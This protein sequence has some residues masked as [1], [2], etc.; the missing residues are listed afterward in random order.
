MRYRPL[1]GRP[2]FTLIELLVV[3]AIIA[4]LIGLLLP[5][6]QK[7]R[8]AANRARCNSN[9]KQLALGCHSY[10]DVFASLPRNGSQLDLKT[11]HG[12]GADRGT[13]CCGVA[14]P[15]WSWIARMLPFTEQQNLYIEAGAP[16]NK[17]SAGRD[18][19]LAIATDL[20]ILYCPND[21]SP[22]VRNNTANLE[23]FSVAVGN[24]HGVSGSNWGTDSYPSEG[25]FNSPYRH[26]GANGSYN[27][28]EKGDGL[29][30]RADI[31]YGQR[32]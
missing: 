29:F 4:V 15:H 13:G 25:S 17:M 20:K 23:G 30:W 31:R 10:H 22:R 12:G 14:A 28:L 6:V 1:H 8:E 21:R 7:V 32:S 18:S 5:A 3:I 11:S 2:A 16:N 9:L 19:L 24:Y 26:L 27:G